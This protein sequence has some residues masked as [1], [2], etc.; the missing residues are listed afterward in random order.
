MVG[1]FDPSADV[2]NTF[3]F[4]PRGKEMTT[5]LSCIL[6][7]SSKALVYEIERRIEK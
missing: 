7:T 2:T 4:P 6:V 5:S 3:S 1:N